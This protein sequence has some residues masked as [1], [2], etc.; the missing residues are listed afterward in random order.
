MDQTDNQ[1]TELGITDIFNF[2]LLS[3]MMVSPSPHPKTD[4]GR[5]SAYVFVL[6]CHVCF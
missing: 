6:D 1:Y 3:V 5:L 2:V 4:S